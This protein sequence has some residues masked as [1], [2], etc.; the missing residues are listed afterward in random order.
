MLQFSTFPGFFWQLT[1]VHYDPWYETRQESCGEDLQDPGKFGNFNCHPPWV[2]VKSSVNA[3]KSIE[4]GANAD[5]IL[6][7][8]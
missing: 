3:M 6:W 5:F 1:D 4:R 2:L 8:G 7:S